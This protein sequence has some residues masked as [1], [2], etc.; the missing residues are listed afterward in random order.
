MHTIR[1][2]V[3]IA[4]MG[5][6][7]P[8]LGCGFEDP[9]S[10]TMQ[11]GALN[12]SYPNALYVMGAA[13]QARSAGI[14]QPDDAGPSEVKDMFAFLKT[15][16][17]LQRFG[18]ERIE[19]GKEANPVVFSLVLVEPMLWTRFRVRGAGVETSVHI[20]GPEPGG[21]V[22][23]TSTAALKA[24]VDHNLTGQRAVDLGLI[25]I[26]GEVDASGRVLE[27]ITEDTQDAAD[28]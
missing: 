13:A 27:M 20:T 16:R 7:W 25:R 1:I 8:A 9:A 10:A 11:R 18:A 28:H 24:I 6:T 22:V 17:M 2:S 5:S 23:V 15:T 14:L 4:L 12:L 3:V 21:P 19:R 26:Y